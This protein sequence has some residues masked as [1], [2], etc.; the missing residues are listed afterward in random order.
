MWPALGGV[1][2]HLQFFFY[3]MGTTYLGEKYEFASWSIHMAF[4]ILFSNL[5]GLYYK[6]W[7]GVHKKTMSTLFLGLA[8]IILSILMIGLSNTFFGE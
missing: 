2:W 5:W 1:T 4:I 8:V 6:E 7:K 3:R